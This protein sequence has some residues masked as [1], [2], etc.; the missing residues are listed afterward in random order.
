MLSLISPPNFL[1]ISRF[2]SYKRNTVLLPALVSRRYQLASSLRNHMPPLMKRK[3]RQEAFKRCYEQVFQQLGPRLANPPTVA[4]PPLESLSTLAPP[5]IRTADP[6]PNAPTPP[7]CEG[8]LIS[9][10]RAFPKEGSEN[11]P[12]KKRAKGLIKGLKA[13]EIDIG[14]VIRNSVAMNQPTWWEL[15]EEERLKLCTGLSICY[16]IKYNQKMY[17]WL[18]KVA[19][20]AYTSWKGKL[21]KFFKHYKGEKAPKEFVQGRRMDEW[22]WL[23]QHFLS[24]QFQKL[25]AAN[26]ANRD[27]L[28]MHHHAGCTPFIYNAEKLRREGESLYL[29]NG[30]EVAYDAPHNEIAAEK[31]N[32]MRQKILTMLSEQQP[33]TPEDELLQQ[34]KAARRSRP[35]D[36]VLEE[37]REHAR[38]AQEEARHAQEEAQQAREQ[39][40]V[41]QEKILD[42]ECRIQMLEKFVQSQ[43]SGQEDQHL[44]VNA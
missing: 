10:R 36:I 16:E 6:P 40:K 35:N 19:N 24:P 30:F 17:D 12:P 13:E 34:G 11:D 7:E 9:A 32:D 5:I 44:E 41:A 21:H 22:N 28:T 18:M 4:A 38:Q 23:K 31:A 43:P 29:I 33:D 20:K 14:R 37:V 3:S 2:L 26:S 8:P 15:K 25:S 1:P 42:Y 27:K 39:A